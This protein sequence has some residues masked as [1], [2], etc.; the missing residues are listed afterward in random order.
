MSDAASAIASAIDPLDR[1]MIRGR[2][3]ALIP[4]GDGLV[5]VDYKT[6]RITTDSIDARA[7]LYREQVTCYR[8]AVAAN[9]AAAG[10]KS[11][12]LVF[13]SQREIRTV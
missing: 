1:V 2:I 11:V 13:L 9:C 5:L 6:D 8:D 7:E 4:D 3:D 10:D 12:H